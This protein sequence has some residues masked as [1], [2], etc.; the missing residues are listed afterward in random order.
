MKQSTITVNEYTTKRLDFPNLIISARTV[1][2]SRCEVAVGYPGLPNAL[3]NLKIGD[4]MLFESPNDGLIEVRLLSS[5]SGSQVELLLT[6]MS[7]R[8][9]IMGGFTDNDQNNDPFTPNEL[10]KVAESIKNIQIELK[11][12]LSITPEQLDLIYRKLN[13]LQNASQR[14]GVHTRRCRRSRGRP[15]YRRRTPHSSARTDT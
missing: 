6:Q 12:N 9:G 5:K 10:A 15:S 7:P 1:F 2:D 8:L 14:L 3:K 4:A 13:D 11:Q